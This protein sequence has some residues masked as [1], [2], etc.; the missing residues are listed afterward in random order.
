MQAMSSFLESLL[1]LPTTLQSLHLNTNYVSEEAYSNSQ[2]GLLDVL[3]GREVDVLFALHSQLLHAQASPEPLY[4]HLTYLVLQGPLP[5]RLYARNLTSPKADVLE[6]ASWSA[7]GMLKVGHDP[8]LL[9]R[10]SLPAAL[11]SVFP[12]G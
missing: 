2:G 9:L 7:E 3:C 10:N 6:D 8:V 4:P 1:S 5:K 11:F 12:N